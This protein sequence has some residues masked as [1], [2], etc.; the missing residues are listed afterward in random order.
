VYEAFVEKVVAATRGLKVG[1]SLDANS[2]Y[3]LGPVSFER[4]LEIVERQVA[5]AV[6]RGARV[7]T[8]GERRGS[9]FEPTV[10][11]NVTSD[12]LVMR[13]EIFGPLMPII[14]V[15]DET[16]AI[17]LAN[18]SPYGLSAAVWSRNHEH[19]V[20]VARK[21]EVGTVAINDTVAHFGVPHLPFGGM[22]ASGFG[23]SHGREGLLQFTQTF[24]FLIGAPPQPFDV[25][26]LLRR[27]GHYQLV[28]AV[29]RLAFGVTPRQRVEPVAEVVK[30]QARRLRPA[31]RAG[32]GLGAAAASLAAVAMAVS[33]ARHRGRNAG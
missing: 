11:V 24:G 1:Y 5:D 28:S 31:A 2:Q 23:R 30:D 12:M 15:R 19:A 14:P 7:L 25:A 29:L 18:D 9:F 27:P 22:K 10:L 6:A 20:R 8:G 4:Q 33:H 13:D 26:T 21:L 16:E 3:Q 17:R 32:L